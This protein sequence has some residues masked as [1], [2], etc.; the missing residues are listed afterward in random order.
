MGEERLNGTAP[1][2]APS[3]ALRLGSLAF[4]LCLV[5]G[6][7]LSGRRGWELDAS[8]VALG[9]IILLYI[10]VFLGPAMALGTVGAAFGE[11]ISQR[12]SVLGVLLAAAGATLEWIF[13]Q[14]GR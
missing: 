14:L 8:L 12:R 10:P 4:A 5:G 11:G 13:W 3:V 1:A 7:I 9:V 6:L 2:K